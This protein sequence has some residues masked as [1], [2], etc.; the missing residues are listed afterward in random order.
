MALTL[1]R[2]AV[3]SARDALQNTE[4]RQQ[5][6]NASP[7]FRMGFRGV[8]KNLP[9]RKFALGRLK[10]KKK[11]GVSSFSSSR[12]V[13]FWTTSRVQLSIPLRWVNLR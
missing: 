10:T 8:N 4:Y 5:L 12:H 11:G 9:P 2:R 6:H 3:F 13:N 7:F 1:T